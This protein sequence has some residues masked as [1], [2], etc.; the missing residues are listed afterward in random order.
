MPS[1]TRT[2]AKNAF[3]HVMDNIIGRDDSTDV[4]K[5]LVD[6]GIEDIFDLVTLDESFID[7]ITF[8]DGSKPPTM[9]QVKKGDRNMIKCF[10]AYK[11]LFDSNNIDI[12]YF[13]LTQDKFDDFRT[14]PSFTF[15]PNVAPPTLPSKSSSPNQPPTFTKAEYFRRSI[16]K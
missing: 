2:E 15:K 1:I 11:N 16:K 13:S 4:K 3:N 8:K 7:S 12:D 9:V 10:I 14:S 5:A 6:Q